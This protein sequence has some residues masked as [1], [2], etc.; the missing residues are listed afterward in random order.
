MFGPAASQ[1][2]VFADVS[3]LVTSAL[4][5]YNVCVFA[6]GQ[7]A[8]PLTRRAAGRARPA[9]CRRGKRRRWTSWFCGSRLGGSGAGL[10][11]RRGGAWRGADGRRQDVHDGGDPGGPGHQLPH[12][13]GTVPVSRGRRRRSGVRR[14]V[15]RRLL[16]TDCGR[17]G[18]GAAGK[19]L[20][21]PTVVKLKVFNK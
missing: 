11:V 20:V 1:A 16:L 2:E 21:P 14:A 15:G 3:Q 18:P 5:G 7:V 13:E 10:A 4:D 12:H 19:E 17:G 9:R 8:P 6:Y